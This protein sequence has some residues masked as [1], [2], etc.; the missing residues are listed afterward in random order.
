MDPDFW[1]D[2]VRFSKPFKCVNGYLEHF[3]NLN[4]KL[5]PYVDQKEVRNRHAEDSKST[6]VHGVAP[7]NRKNALAVKNK[8][9]F[10]FF[11]VCS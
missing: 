4:I 8:D 10:G 6:V 11:E 7:F 1:K 2:G 3:L 9:F 5:A